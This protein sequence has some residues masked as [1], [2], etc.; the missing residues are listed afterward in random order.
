M[1]SRFLE[2]WVQQRA[3]QGL[4][5]TR[6][7]PTYLQAAENGKE[8]VK[9]HDVAVDCHEPQEPRGA[10]KQQ[11][12][13]RCPQHRAVKQTQMDICSVIG[14]KRTA[15]LLPVGGVMCPTTWQLEKP[16]GKIRAV[17]TSS[18]FPTLSQQYSTA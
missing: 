7:H 10:D 13:E 1:P 15:Q 14:Y 11:E 6:W 8:I 18:L 9:C 3:Y 4:P 17:F 2:V 5:Q 16:F 12:Q